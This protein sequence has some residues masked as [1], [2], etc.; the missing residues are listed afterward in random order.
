MAQWAEVLKSLNIAIL[1]ISKQKLSYILLALV[2]IITIKKK[3][4]KRKAEST[5]LYCEDKDKTDKEEGGYDP[6]DSWERS[7]YW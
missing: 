4:K 3:E 7:G 5:I 2:V 6:S 1:K